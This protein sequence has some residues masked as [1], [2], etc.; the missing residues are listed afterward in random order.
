V[1]RLQPRYRSVRDAIGAGDVRQAF[2]AFAAGNSLSALVWRQLGRAPHVDAGGFGATPLASTSPDKFAL[3]LGD[4][5][6]TLSIIIR[7]PCGVVVSAQTSARDLKPAQ[8]SWPSVRNAKKTSNGRNHHG[9]A[10][11]TI[12]IRSRTAGPDN[13]ESGAME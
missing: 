1:R 10:D 5:P 3:E 2:T 13:R 6:S 9:N 8:V 4:P 12:A 11:G 7:R